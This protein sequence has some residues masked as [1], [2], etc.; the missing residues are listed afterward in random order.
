MVLILYKITV[1]HLWYKNN[2]L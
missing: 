2:S 1:T